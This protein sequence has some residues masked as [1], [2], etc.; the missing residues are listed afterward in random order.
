MNFWE[1]LEIH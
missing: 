1:V